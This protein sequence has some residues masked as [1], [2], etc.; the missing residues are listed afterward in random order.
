MNKWVGIILV[1]SVFCCDYY[2][3]I[4]VVDCCCE[5]VGVWELYL[6]LIGIGLVG[7]VCRCNVCI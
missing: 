7:V 5:L 1:L 4:C 2:C 6:Y 3:F